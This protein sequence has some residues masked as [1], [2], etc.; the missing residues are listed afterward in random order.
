MTPRTMHAQR[1][2]GRMHT[3]YVR[4]CNAEVGRPGKWHV[5]QRT[6]VVVT[7]VTI[8]RS[9]LHYCTRHRDHAGHRPEYHTAVIHRTE[10][11]TPVQVKGDV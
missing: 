5:C 9:V 10:Y 6:D 11:A 7:I 1:N 2:G 8:H 3:N 4:R